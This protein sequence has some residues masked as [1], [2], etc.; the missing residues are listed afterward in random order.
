MIHFEK[1]LGWHFKETGQYPPEQLQAF[2]FAGQFDHMY[3][4]ITCKSS[5]YLT[6]VS[7]TPK[8]CWV[9]P[10]NAANVFKYVNL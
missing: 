10:V 8:Q 6:M 2:R 7:D 3:M 1:S 4:H 5:I 9:G